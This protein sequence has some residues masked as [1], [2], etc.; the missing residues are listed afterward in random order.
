M[1]VSAKSHF[2]QV[3]ENSNRRPRSR[4]SLTLSLICENP[5]ASIIVD[6]RTVNK[7]FT[8]ENKNK[9]SLSVLISS[10]NI[11]LEV[12]SSAIDDS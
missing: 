1:E 2:M 4:Q 11:G 8:L 10:I 6:G 3:I 9:A 5:S 12:L 7:P